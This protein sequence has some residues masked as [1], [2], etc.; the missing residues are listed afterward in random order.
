MQEARSKSFIKWLVSTRRLVE[1][2]IGQLTDE[3]SAR[4]RGKNEWEWVF[5]N[6]EV[7]EDPSIEPTNNSSERQLRPSV[8]FR[9]VTNGFRSDW[10]S[11]FFSVVRSIISTGSRQGLSPYQS[12]QKALNP[13]LCFFPL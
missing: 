1:T 9:K 4:V 7:F 12:I 8:I 6:D 5:Q 3:T 13:Q 2:V 11:D 10:G